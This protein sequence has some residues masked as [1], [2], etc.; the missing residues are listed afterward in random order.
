[1]RLVFYFLFL[2]SIFGAKLSAQTVLSG[3]IQNLNGGRVMYIAPLH[4]SFFLSGYQPVEVDARGHFTVEYSTIDTTS[5]VSFYAENR[6][7]RVFVNPND[8]DSLTF[9]FANIDTT[10]AFFGKNAKN[11][12][13]LNTLKHEKYFSGF[14]ETAVEQQLLKDFTAPVVEYRIGQLRTAE[15][16]SLA[17]FASR[18]QADSGFVKM[19]QNDIRYYYASLFNSLAI[20]AFQPKKQVAGEP[21]PFNDEWAKYWNIAIQTEKINNPEALS[22]YWYH[23]WMDKFVD[24]YHGAYKKEIKKEGLDLRK[25]ENIFEIEQLIRQYF[26]GPSLEAALADMIYD[27]ALQ[28]QYQPVLI[29]IYN[30]FAKE[31]PYSYYHRY[32]RRVITPIVK[33][34]EATPIDELGAIYIIDNP[35]KVNTFDQLLSNFRGKTIYVDLWAT[36]C[37][38]CKQE[39]AYQADL[40]KYVKDKNIDKLFI[41]IDKDEKQKQWQESLSFYNLNGHHIRAS[42]A[43]IADLRSRFSDTTGTLFI[44][45]YVIVAPDGKIMEA[46]AKRPSERG[47]LY[48]QLGK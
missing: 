36:W 4:G 18:T 2:A 33:K 43:L 37:G 26:V 12:Q 41:S 24:W 13:F 7:W 3:Q 25:G 32:L 22:S 20:A 23:E 47:A 15:L 16:D 46:A 34:W 6:Y 21:T 14:L 45:R 48:E 35:E 31:F 30:R 17:V 29:S 39:F 9:D 8:R 19:V 42:A 27:E 1:V 10:L 38:P 28:E 11:N 40:D 5:I 44:P